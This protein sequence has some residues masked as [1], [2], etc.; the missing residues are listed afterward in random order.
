MQA[1]AGNRPSRPLRPAMHG[2][3]YMDSETLLWKGSSHGGFAPL[4]ETHLKQSMAKAMQ[5][6]I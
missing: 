2:A 4:F 3:S 1:V 5:K 6:Q